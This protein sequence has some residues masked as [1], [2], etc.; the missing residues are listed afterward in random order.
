MQKGI[1]EGSTR[2]DHSGVANQ[3]FAAYARGVD[4]RD[5]SVV[6]GGAARA[7]RGVGRSSAPGCRAGAAG[8][9]R[10]KQVH[11]GAFQLREGRA[12]GGD[13]TRLHE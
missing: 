9:G 10:A 8:G 6:L 3:L 5:L 1:G 2:A 13:G 7:C 11:A 4:A 12:V